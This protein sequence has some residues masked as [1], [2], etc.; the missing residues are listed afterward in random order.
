MHAKVIYEKDTH[1]YVY[2]HAYTAKTIS[3]IQNK[4]L[5]THIF[6][7]GRAIVWFSGLCD[8]LHAWPNKHMSKP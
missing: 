3:K 6:S 1:I 7:F 5:S 8:V 4:T 2:I